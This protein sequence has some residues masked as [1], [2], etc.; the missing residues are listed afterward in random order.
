[1]EEN[2]GL[3]EVAS[4]VCSFDG[5]LDLEALNIICSDILE[6]LGDEGCDHMYLH[7]PI[8]Q[9]KSSRSENRKKY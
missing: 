4:T 8:S 7:T 5:N 2:L 9:K 6:G 1:M 3:M